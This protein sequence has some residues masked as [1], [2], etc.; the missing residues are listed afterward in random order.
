MCLIFN[1]LFLGWSVG[2][3][4]KLTWQ[5]YIFNLI[6]IIICCLHQDNLS[7]FMMDMVSSLCETNSL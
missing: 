2:L 7:I 6:C 3:S 1:S 5:N 4:R